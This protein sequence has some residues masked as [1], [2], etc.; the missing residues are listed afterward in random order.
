MWRLVF[1]V[2]SLWCHGLICSVL[3][4]SYLVILTYGLFTPMLPLFCREKASSLR[5]KCLICSSIPIVLQRIIRSWTK[6]WLGLQLT[7]QCNHLE[8]HTHLSTSEQSLTFLYGRKETTKLIRSSDND[9]YCICIKSLFQNARTATCIYLR[10]R[11]KWLSKTT[12]LLYVYKLM[13]CSTYI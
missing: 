4:W 13:R 6:V 10:Y 3:L 7:H 5:N 12:L 8:W 2:S 11:P 1:C 9:T